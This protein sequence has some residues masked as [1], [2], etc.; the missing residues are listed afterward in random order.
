MFFSAPQ[1]KRDPLGVTSSTMSREQ[2]LILL[3]GLAGLLSNSTARAQDSVSERLCPS[4]PTFIDCLR[5][6]EDQIFRAHPGLAH[7]RGSDLVLTL[8]SGDGVIVCDTVTFVKIPYGADTVTADGYYAIY[9]LKDINES[10]GY[11]VLAMFGYEN[12][13]ALVV[14][15][16]TGWRKF[17]DFNLPVFDSAG[18]YAAAT[19]PARTAYWEPA[20]DVFRVS[21]DSLTSEFHFPS[22]GTRDAFVR[23]DTLWGP[24]NL[25]WEGDQLLVDTEETVNRHDYWSG[26]PQVLAK[27]NARWVRRPR[28]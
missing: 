9:V 10:A 3:A 12:R 11:F 14:S 6:G 15:R 19:I 17:I 1:L 5:Q 24:T 23:G 28:K 27:L 7:R 18:S 8:A 25:H 4:G 26:K 20:I 16:R 13:G 21:A 22:P 2:C